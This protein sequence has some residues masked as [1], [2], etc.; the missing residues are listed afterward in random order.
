MAKKNYKKPANKQ[1]STPESEAARQQKAQAAAQA[2]QVREQTRKYNTTLIKLKPFAAIAVAILV[3]VL[4]LF[5]VNWAYVY[6][7]DIPGTEVSFSGWSAAVSGIT[8][9][10]MS[11]SSIYGDLAVPFYY[12]AQSYCTR[13]STLTLIALLVIVVTLVLQIVAFVKKNYNMNLIAAVTG[14]VCAVLLFICNQTALSMKNGDILTIYC[15]GNPACSIRSMAFVPAIFMLVAV[16]VNVFICI[17]VM[18]AR[19][20]LKG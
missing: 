1:V 5:F 10:F 8:R 3:A 15:Q 6:N 13:L 9:D 11:T 20:A 19:K 2:A 16:A 4:L 17:R 14:L 12:Y 18:Q 7:T